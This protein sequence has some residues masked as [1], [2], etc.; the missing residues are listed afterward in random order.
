MGARSRHLVI[1]LNDLSL[2]KLV[3]CHRFQAGDESVWVG[4]GK[5]CFDLRK[6]WRAE[7]NLYQQ[8]LPVNVESTR[9]VLPMKKT[10]HSEEDGLRVVWGQNKKAAK[11]Y[12]AALTVDSMC[13]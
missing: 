10:I 12:I 3:S 4:R 6:R 13:I 2:M 9:E 5:C 1:T 11:T 7:L 8:V